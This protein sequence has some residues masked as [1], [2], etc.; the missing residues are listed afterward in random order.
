MRAGVEREFPVAEVNET[1][2]KNDGADHLDEVPP[3]ELSAL[4]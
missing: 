2:Q 3:E 4:N 1:R